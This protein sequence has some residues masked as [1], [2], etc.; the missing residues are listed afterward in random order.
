MAPETDRSA[1]LS[2]IQSVLGSADDQFGTNLRRVARSILLHRITLSSNRREEMRFL[3]SAIEG[4]ERESKNNEKIT[5]ATSEL[6]SILNGNLEE[7][8]VGDLFSSI[9]DVP[10]ALSP[11]ELYRFATDLRKEPIHF[12]DSDLTQT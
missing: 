9:A 3:L 8:S 7:K 6:V 4:I 5:E 10:D 12:R 2:E 1:R 11:A